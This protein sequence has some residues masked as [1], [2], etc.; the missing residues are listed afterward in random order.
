MK[1]KETERLE[2]REKAI[3]NLKKFEFD[4]E[5]RAKRQLMREE[6]DMREFKQKQVEL[7]MVRDQ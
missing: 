1:L 4:Q 2:A 6:E 3:A 7:E 5:E